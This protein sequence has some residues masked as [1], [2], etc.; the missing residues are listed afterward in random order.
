MIDILWLALKSLSPIVPVYVKQAV[1][2]VNKTRS[3]M[4][5]FETSSFLFFIFGTI[6]K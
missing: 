4:F 5:I 1:N 3:F 2:T 6:D